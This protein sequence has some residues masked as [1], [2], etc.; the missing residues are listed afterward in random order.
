MSAHDADAIEEALSHALSNVGLPGLDA[1]GKYARLVAGSSLL[2]HLCSPEDDE[3]G[4]LTNRMLLVLESQPLINRGAY[5]R[6]LSSTIDAYW[7]NEQLHPA[8]YLPIV[9]VN[10]IVRYWRTVLL[11]H[12][13]RLRK[14]RNTHSLSEAETIALRRYSSYKLRDPRCL[15]CFSALAYLLALT[16]TEPSHVSRTDVAEMVRLTPLERL[17]WLEQNP[18]TPR[19]IITTLRDCYKRFLD[20]IGAGKTALT[21]ALM[22]DDEIVQAVSREGKQFTESMFQL[23]E[24][25]GGGRTLHRA[26]VV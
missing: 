3:S 19:D 14:K 15:S 24:A 8:D 4:A 5:E 25:L 16:P 17:E 2:Q 1:D 6:L 26:I 12:E 21:D 20:R 13:S 11:N 9:L 23:V 22:N 7:Q 18:A 10:D